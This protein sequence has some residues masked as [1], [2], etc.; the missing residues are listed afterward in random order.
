M[1]P[2]KAARKQVKRVRCWMVTAHG[3][4]SRNKYR[5]FYGTKWEA[6]RI[7]EFGGTITPGWFVADAKQRKGKSK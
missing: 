6:E 3:R 1:T 4:I 2:K 7:V 5:E